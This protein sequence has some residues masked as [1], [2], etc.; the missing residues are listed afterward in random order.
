MAW[1]GGA[2][3]RRSRGL[4]S[5]DRLSRCSRRSAGY[6]N[7]GGR[8]A[9]CFP[10]IG[11]AIGL[12]LPATLLFD[13]PTVAELVRFLDSTIAKSLPNVEALPTTT[14]AQVRRALGSISL[15]DLKEAGLLDAL[16]KLAERGS[17]QARPDTR[18]EPD[19]AERLESATDD[20]LRRSIPGHI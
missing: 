13:Y 19:L 5:D 4:E 17:P 20:Q 8:L 12:R 14:E 9:I 18:N 11:A 3:A 6:A 7:A 16:L 10:W 2:P 15:G 1:L